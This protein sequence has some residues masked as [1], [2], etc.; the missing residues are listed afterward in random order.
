M[1][2]GAKVKIMTYD[3]VDFMKLCVKNYEEITKVDTL[4]Q[5]FY[6]FHG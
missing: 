1:S 3:H 4:K 2:N 6:S 5:V